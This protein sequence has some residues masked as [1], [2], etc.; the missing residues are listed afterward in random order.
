MRTV[1]AY[2]LIPRCGTQRI[3]DPSERA[4]FGLFT[5][6]PILHHNLPGEDEGRG[7]RQ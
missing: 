3:V 5:S 7:D 6:Y 4:R 2:C 1:Y